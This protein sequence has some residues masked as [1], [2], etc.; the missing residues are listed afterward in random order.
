MSGPLRM[1]AE[2][3]LAA[4]S[5][6]DGPN[7]RLVRL[8][9]PRRGAG[10]GTS[11][12]PTMMAVAAETFAQSSSELCTASARLTELLTALSAQHAEVQVALLRLPLA[13]RQLPAF[14]AL[15]GAAPP[16]WEALL[17]DAAAL[18]DYA[19]LC[20]KQG[21][22]PVAAEAARRLADESEAS[23]QS[24][25]SSANTSVCGAAVLSSAHRVRPSGCDADA[26]SSDAE[27]LQFLSDALQKES[28]GRGGLLALELVT[29]ITAMLSQLKLATHEAYLHASSL[30]LGLLVGHLT[31]VSSALARH[32]EHV[33]EAGRMLAAAGALPVSAAAA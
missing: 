11:L 3:S 6:A 26:A 8:L 30:A 18:C 14:V 1:L 32:T 27:M 20:G 16:A 9:G 12:S 31:A 21:L 19:I 25:E 4:F 33:R 2:R 7:E 13:E 22:G 23:M 15:S 28:I 10:G 17:R 24:A 5:F 29:R